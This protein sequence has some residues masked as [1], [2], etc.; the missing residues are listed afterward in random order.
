MTAKE[1]RNKNFEMQMAQMQSCCF[2]FFNKLLLQII[3][4]LSS[5]CPFAVVVSL[6]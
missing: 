1:K 3:I 5:R 2:F 6:R 4:F